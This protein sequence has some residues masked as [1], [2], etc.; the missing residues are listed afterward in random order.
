ML[1]DGE[2][3]GVVDMEPGAEE[4]IVELMLGPSDERKDEPGRRL[5]ATTAQTTESPPRRQPEARL[6]LA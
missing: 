3:V 1:R 5:A 6:N 2:T 4:R